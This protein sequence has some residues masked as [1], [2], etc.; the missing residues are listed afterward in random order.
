MTG[1]ERSGGGPGGS[2]RVDAGGEQHGRGPEMQRV[3]ECCDDADG[4]PAGEVRDDQPGADPE[5]H[6]V[7]QRRP[8]RR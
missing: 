1:H 7:V 3:V 4:L 8:A 5:V 2:P 6:H